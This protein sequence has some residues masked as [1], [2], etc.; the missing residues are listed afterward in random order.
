MQQIPKYEIDVIYHSGKEMLLVHALPITYLN[1]AYTS[2]IYLG[3]V[4]FKI[5][6]C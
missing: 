1:K 3:I 5:K 2:D 6:C 4:E